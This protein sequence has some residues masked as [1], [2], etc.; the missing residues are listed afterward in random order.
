MSLEEQYKSLMELREDVRACERLLAES[1]E[2]EEVATR[3]FLEALR[4]AEKG[5]LQGILT[6]E[7]QESAKEPISSSVP[8][9]AATDTKERPEKETTE[10][11]EERLVSLKK[12]TSLWH[13][14]QFV[15]HN[16]S[17]R[18]REIVS[19]PDLTSKVV[20]TTISAALS[21]LVRRGYLSRING[22]YGFRSDL[23]RLRHKAGASHKILKRVR[24]ALGS[25]DWTDGIVTTKAVVDVTGFGKSSVVLAFR[26]LTEEGTLVR[27]DHRNWK[28][29][30]KENLYD[31]LLSRS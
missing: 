9:E 17:M 16:E 18:T 2:A 6:V 31:L 27:V 24:A 5:S 30:Q 12:G 29:V 21:E 14:F 10:P 13:V 19:H 26:Y 8:V 4:E 23:G 11:E 20:Q 28:I 25:R 1:R 22:R 7:E 15:K 3:R